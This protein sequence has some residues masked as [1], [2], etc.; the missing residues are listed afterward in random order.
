VTDQTAQT[1]V[2]LS[3]SVV[4][5][6][7]SLDE[8]QQ[9]IRSSLDAIAH[10]KALLPLAK[11]PFI[12]IDNS[13]DSANPA[14]IPSDVLAEFKAQADS[15]E[16][17]LR[18]IRGHGNVGYG[19]GHNL[20]LKPLESRF[21]LLLNPDITL[22]ED[23]ISEGL[24]Y[25]LNEP[26]AVMASPHATNATGEK[27]HLCK[28][29]PSVATL[30]V[31]GFLPNGWKTQFAARLGRY[32]MRE[33]SETAPTAP[34]PIASGCF[35]LCTS[36]ALL[37]VG[38]FDE[39]YFLYFEDF[40]LSLRLGELGQIAYVPAMKICHGGGYAAKKGIR[41]IAMF[42][43]SGIRFFNTHGWRWFS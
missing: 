36:E 30:F 41:H 10:A 28:R 42:A 13:D 20:A 19:R 2:S 26:S 23:C 35:M 7:N 38:G 37:A 22:N 33:L 39:R 14:C 32:E 40:D 29:Y 16:V 8:L 34:I 4:C 15:L 6:H 5:Y 12:L 31:R 3:I 27:Q 24:K 9:L 25:L 11:I 1:I 21:H 17:E 43:R 18:L